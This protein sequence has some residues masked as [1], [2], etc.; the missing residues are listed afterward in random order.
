[1]ANAQPGI[2][3]SL[4][5]LVAEPATTLGATVG[6]AADATFFGP[7]NVPCFHHD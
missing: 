4:P 2:A 6:A 5:A 1:M 3:L 7:Y